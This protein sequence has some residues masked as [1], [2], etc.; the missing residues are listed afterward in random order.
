MIFDVRFLRNP[1]WEDQLRPLDGQHADVASYV[2]ADKAF[3]P[4]FAKLSELVTSLLPLFKAEGKTHFSI[5]IGCTGGQHRSVTVAEKLSK[6]LA[7]QG[8]RVS[9]RHRELER[10][11]AERPR[12]TG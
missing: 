3:G 1:H 7:E 11:G 10:R 2:E 8:W 12:G 9:T 4:F 5:G 6:A